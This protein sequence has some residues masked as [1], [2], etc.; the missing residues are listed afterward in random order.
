LQLQLSL[1]LADDL[2]DLLLLRGEPV[3]Y[4]FAAE[5]LLALRGSPAALC[6]QVMATLVEEDRRFCWSSPSTIGLGDWRLNDPDL[7]EVN[8]VVVDLETTGTRAGQGKITEIGAVRI[9]GLREVR[10]FETLV[11]PQ[12]PIAPKVIEITGITPQMVLGAPRIEEVMP[13]FLDFIQGAVLVAHN[14]VFDLSFLNYELA[15]LK[16]RRLGEG[17]ID[18]VQLARCVAPGLDNYK[19]GTVSC[20]LGSPVR[21][22][23]R[24]L[25]DAQAT[26]HVFLTLVGRLQEQGVTRLNQL[27]I[28]VDPSHKGD[29]HKITLTRDIPRS[30]GTYLFLGEEGDV[31]YVGKA[32]VLRDRVRSYFLS[33]AH[34]SRKVRQAVRRLRKVDWEETVSPLEAAVREQELILA[35]RPPANV[36]GRRPENY[37]YLKMA[38]RPG[39]G[40]RL[41]L[42]D[43]PGTLGKDNGHPDRT[44]AGQG[45]AAGVTVLGPFRARSRAQSAVELLQRCYPIR[46]CAQAN[47][48]GRPCLFGA[49]GRCLAPCKG[50]AAERDVHD[51]LVRLSLAWICG[52]GGMA[53]GPVER[54]KALMQELSQQ[55]RYEE[56]E[57]VRAAVEELRSLRRS[58]RALSEARRLTAGA[59]WPVDQSPGEVR[60]DLVWRGRLVHRLTL[61]ESTAALEVGRALRSL[62]PT[63]LSAEEGA[64]AG[65]EG[66][67]LATVAVPQEELD[68]L[69]VARRWFLDTPG[70]IKIYLPSSGTPEERVDAWREALLAGVR[71]WLLRD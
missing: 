3:D 2:Y 17:A 59:L 10:H 45:R 41:Y 50:D 46:R 29:R 65:R 19:L 9:E 22:C 13:H 21:S 8:F 63:E 70:A 24:A 7:N 39:A 32:E 43:R 64:G 23:H 55:Q 26:A 28:R 31:L 1:T 67:G 47:R 34:H 69:L 6:R 68:L 5:R 48:T 60:L 66:N 16:G 49:T 44:G 33:G 27:R 25:A 11:N 57:E 54:A 62:D 15:R 42:S 37:V 38:G 12:R 51:E 20:A 40:L 61:S 58:Y 4:L 14:A 36:L 71:G 52:E 18:T 35:H 30:P 56:A 53:E